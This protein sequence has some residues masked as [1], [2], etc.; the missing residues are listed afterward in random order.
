MAFKGP[1]SN[2]QE[3]RITP[4]LL[5][6]VL[7]AVAI[8]SVNLYRPVGNILAHCGA[9][10]LDAISVEAVSNAIS[11]DYLPFVKVCFPAMY[12]A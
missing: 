2:F 12:S 9:V 10:Q 6:L 5:D 7:S 11:T 8:T 3:F 4:Q 1:A